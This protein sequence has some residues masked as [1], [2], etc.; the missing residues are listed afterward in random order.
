MKFIFAFCLITFLN[1]CRNNTTVNQATSSSTE[2]A[3]DKFFKSS[4]AVNNF[5]GS[6][7]GNFDQG[8]ITVVLNY[9]NGKAVSG[10]NLHKG[11]RRSINGTLK[12]FENGYK[13]VLKE[14]GDNPY[15]GTFEFTIDTSKFA[16][17]GMWN[18]FDTSKT[19]AKK[20][21]LT[22]QE[23]KPFEYDK[24]LGMW[25]PATGTYSTDT[26][27]DF[28]PEGTCEYKFYQKPGDSTSQ[29]NS[30]RG[31]YIVHKDT[32]LIDWQKNTFTPSQK[33][34]LIR[35]TKKL[36]EGGNE[37]EEQQLIG[38]GWKFSKFEGD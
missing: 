15:D 24:E 6:Y 14:P 19:K 26:T 7:A 35:R 25:V 8:F 30:V 28:A 38:D 27:L 1:S 29:V 20:L 31:N 23:K 32:V 21:S 13:F 9:I 18:P 10:Y 12:P 37:Y 34:K 16:M 22:K 2:L 33:M 17:E 11:L 3:N 4:Y 36:K 5:E